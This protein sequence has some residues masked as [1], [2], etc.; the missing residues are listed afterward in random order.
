MIRSGFIIKEFNE[1]PSWT[2]KKLPG[3][4]TVYAIK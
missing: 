2:N 1:E 3:E 4:I